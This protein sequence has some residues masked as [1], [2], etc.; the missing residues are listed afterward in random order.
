[1]R[2]RIDSLTDYSKTIRR[3]GH[4]VQGNIFCFL[5]PILTP[6]H[7]SLIKSFED[8]RCCYCP[9]FLP[10]YNTLHPVFPQIVYSFNIF[11]QVV[12]NQCF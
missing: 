1:M 7:D 4:E 8:K 10:E 6:L 12:E 2:K 3:R 11:R 9:Y 5:P